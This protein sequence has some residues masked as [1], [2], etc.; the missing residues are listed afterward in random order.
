MLSRLW[1]EVFGLPLHGSPPTF[2]DNASI[3]TWAV[4][5]VGKMQASQIMGGTGNN[6]FSPSGTFTREQ[7]IMTI[8]RLFNQSF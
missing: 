5:A 7:S 1:F 2:A 3:S 6:N 8:L 4:E